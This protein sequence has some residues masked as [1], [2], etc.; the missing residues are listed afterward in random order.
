M[1][2][3][4]L[5]RNIKLE[6]LRLLAKHEIEIFKKIDPIVFFDEI[7]DLKK[8][9]STDARYKDARGDLI[10]HYINNND[11]ELDYILLE[12]FNF[13]D[14][15]EILIGLL[16]KIISPEV[17]END[18]DIKFFYHTLNP[19]LKNDLIE[20]RLKGIDDNGLSI[21]EIDELDEDNKFKDLADNKIPF[22]F[23]NTRHEHNSYFLLSPTT[24]DD[25]GNKNEFFL[26][27]FSNNMRKDIGK[28]KIISKQSNSTTKEIV[29]KF[30]TLSNEYCSLGQNFDFYR[31]LKNIFQQNYL[32]ILKGLNDITFFP[33]ICE[34]FENF[35]DFKNSIIR[36]DE[37]EQLLRQ[38]RYRIDNYD[39]SNL[40]SFEYNFK[41]I[42]SDDEGLRI[43]FNF[44]DSSILPNRIYALIGNNGVGKTQLVS[45]LP[46]D[47]AKGN[48]ELFTPKLPLFSKV[49]AVSYSVF[50]K[51]VIPESSS[52]I[53]YIYC[54][55]RHSKGSSE[56]ILSENELN[57]RF[58][59]SIVKV[60]KN[61]RFSSW[62]EII[63][64]FFPKELVD[65]WIEWDSTVFEQKLNIVEINK[66][67]K[68]FS[69]GQA[70][71]LYILT[72][73]LANIRYDSLII[74]DE[75]ETHLHPNAI[76]QLINSIHLLVKKFQSFC[77]IATHSP[78]IVQG[79]LSK[80]I[81]VI[82]NENNILN[83]KHPAIE[84]FGENLTKI[85]EDIFGSRETDSQFKKELEILIKKGYSFEQILELLR[86]N[87]IP[88]S[89]NLTVLLKSMVSNSYD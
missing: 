69:S 25:Y 62:I 30:Y 80:N 29:E 57:S 7:L 85:T 4:Q 13:I 5:K 67:L 43:A 37:Q 24:W 70:I 75:P 21:F 12:R 46:F 51:F 34:E 45:K 26:Y 52:K 16:N 72:E 17:N 50:D 54:G 18:D 2:N 68:T 28:L 41:P 33:Q 44:N 58:F 3:F 6:I 10:Q 9:P 73:I 64:N 60:Q 78:I 82:R 53:N 40:Y 84:T 89:L 55:L 66:S 59:L 63:K 36:F 74:F 48:F 77:I 39:L 32:S 11:W 71:F 14:S 20:Y 61:K 49:I 15:D 65:V 23:S 27:Y 56:S 31:N 86:E 8:L 47:I 83:A 81:Y 87:N 22:V 35:S 76:S 79:I 38:A 1:K 19:I 88:L 42:Y